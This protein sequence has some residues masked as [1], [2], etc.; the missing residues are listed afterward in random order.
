MQRISLV[1]TLTILTSAAITDLRTSRVP[2][3]LTLPF[4]PIGLLLCGFPLSPESYNRIVWLIVFF[5]F[6]TFRLMGMGDLKLCMAVI[7]L[8]G[9]QKASV[10]LLAGILIL[11][12]YCMVTEKKQTIQMLKDTANFFLHGIKIPHRI[13]RA[14]PFALFL[15][16]GFGC[17][18]FI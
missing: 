3:F 8:Q 2:N 14:Y 11:L 4:L 12:S 7:A 16:M 15:A 1:L 9:I 5:F 17:T 10:M 6:G 13:D 18:F